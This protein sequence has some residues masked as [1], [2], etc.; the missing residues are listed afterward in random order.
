MPG[1]ASPLLKLPM[2]KHLYLE[3]VST[4]QLIMPTHLGSLHLRVE[5]FLTTSG[6]GV[7]R[8]VVRRIVRRRVLSWVFIVEWCGKRMSECSRQENWWDMSICIF[9]ERIYADEA[10]W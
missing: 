4:I 5:D 9:G 10:S 6:V 1:A 2:Q 3:S 7:A 8:V